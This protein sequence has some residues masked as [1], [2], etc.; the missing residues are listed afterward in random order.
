MHVFNVT[1]TSECPACAEPSGILVDWHMLG[2][3]G[4]KCVSCGAALEVQHERSCVRWSGDESDAAGPAIN[5]PGGDSNHER[6]LPRMNEPVP[7]G[8]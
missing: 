1:K 8:V 4:L 3:E 5:D 7:G 2:I 6:E